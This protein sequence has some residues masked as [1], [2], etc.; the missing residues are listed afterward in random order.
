MTRHFAL[1]LLLL[2]SSA[3]PVAARAQDMARA[4]DAVPQNSVVRL[5]GPDLRRVQGRIGEVVGDTVFVLSGSR[6]IAV[7][8]AAITRAEVAT[9]RDHLRG[10]LKGARIGAVV[11]GVIGAALITPHCD[12]CDASQHLQFAAVGFGIGAIYFAVPG[13]LVGLVIGTQNWEPVHPVYG[14]G[15]MPAGDGRMGIGLSLPTP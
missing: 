11:G 10:L 7:P 12:N 8:V 3:L 2:I 4:L 9:D 15:P 1:T 13:G 14:F 5:R 6:T